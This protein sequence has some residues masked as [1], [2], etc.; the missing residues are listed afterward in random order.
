[1]LL[2]FIFLF[3]YTTR[4]QLFEFAKSRLKLSYQR[5]LIDYCLKQGFIASYHD[6]FFNLKVFH[7]TKKGIGFLSRYELFSRRY[8]FDHN[9]TGFNTFEH[10][11]AVIESYFLLYKQLQIKEWVP[12]WVLKKDGKKRDKIPDGVIILH[13]GIRIALEMETWYKQHS[14][15]MCVVYSYRREMAGRICD[16]RYDAVL[17]IAYSSS[18]YE[19]IKNRLFRIKPEFC[20]RA[21]MLTDLILL[22]RGECFY[23]DQIGQIEE[24]L[25][26]IYAAKDK[27]YD[28]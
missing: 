20:K 11:K 1:M 12:E 15:W 7:L 14:A 6:P 23:Q 5:W 26:L 17:F 18:N 16:P 24:A 28:E 27:R 22:E 25:S 13:S 8:R 10:Q 21:F 9:K 4:E 3:R 2:R 19:G